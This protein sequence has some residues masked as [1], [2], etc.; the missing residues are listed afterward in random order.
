MSFDPFGNV[1]VLTGPTGSG[2]TALAL[3][4]ADQLGA[5]IVSMDSMAV[6]RHMDIG[7][8]K[9]GPEDRR[10]VRHHLLDVLEPWESANVA[11]W[12]QNAE[13][14]VRDIAERGKRA[15]FV[16][17]TP[18]YLKALLRGLFDGPPADLQLRQRLTAEAASAGD[19]ALHDRLAQVD[20]VSA[21]RLHPHDVR[22]VIR[23]LEVWE[24]TRQP[25]SSWQKQWAAEIGD[26]TR[27]DGGKDTL[28]TMPR[29]LCLDV[30]RAELYERI[31]ERVRQMIAAGLV[32]E[33]AALRRLP[34]PVSREAAQAVGYKELFAHL[35]G[36]MTLADAMQR[37]QV[38]SRNLA[39]RQLTW[40][41]HLPECRLVTPQLTIAA[42]GL[43]MD[44]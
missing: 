4:L 42:W 1:L 33:A 22:R 8:A 20:R 39:K 19:Q 10:R 35:D 44:R 34:H 7:T 18:L 15:L 36:Q 16:G 37:I 11:W 9:P 26:E 32:E 5:E 23:A 13:A 25:I 17:G 14:A 27:T 12:L 41:R 38:R 21:D 43:T 28:A 2:K 29:V 3:Q 24:L 31:E 40:F 30:P 6:Y